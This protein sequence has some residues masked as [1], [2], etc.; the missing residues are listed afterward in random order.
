M[1]VPS[2]KTTQ[3]YMLERRETAM[4]S[5]PRLLGYRY[6]IDAKKIRIGLLQSALKITEFKAQLCESNHKNNEPTLRLCVSTLEKE[7]C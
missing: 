2:K 6:Q 4:I 3:V 7:R 5:F 1:G